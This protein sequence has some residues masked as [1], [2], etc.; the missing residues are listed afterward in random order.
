ME[1]TTMIDPF[2]HRQPD[3]TGPA[4]DLVPVT[5]DDAADLPAVAAGL[6]VETGGAVSF[7][8]AAGETRTV[9]VGDLSL[10]PVR[11]R[12]VRASGTD[13]AGIHALTVA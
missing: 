9:T 6:Y 13:A 2:K 5:P 7:V 8:S 1:A 10:L 12:R 11:V 3:L 4:A